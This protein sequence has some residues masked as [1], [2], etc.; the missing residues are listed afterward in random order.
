M[1][2]ALFATLL[3]SSFIFMACGDTN[4]TDSDLNTETDVT[5]NETFEERARREVMSYLA[6]PA[7]EKFSIKIYKEYLSSDTIQDAVITVNRLEFAMDRAIKNGKEA[8]AAELGFTGN[9][10]YIF[11]YDG[12]LDKIS[13]PIFAPSS[14]GRELD[15]EFRSIC[16]PTRKDMIVG[17]RI[18]NS[19]W[20][21]YFS[22]FN[23]HDMMMVF[24]WKE[25]DHAGTDNPEA[26]LHTFEEN[27][28]SIAQDICIYESEI[29]NYDKNIGNEYA[30]VPSITKKKK[31]LLKFLL[32]PIEKKYHLYSEYKHNLPQ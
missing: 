18:R 15:I 20:K 29:D 25:F 2:T 16:S 12:A 13:N 9:Y 8:K 31:I 21:S 27:P 10:N 17:Y 4:N 32:D 14:P 26:L 19:G 28:G 7:N 22:V 6:I 30:Y 1:K 23:E 5:S 24:Q 3:L 11:Y